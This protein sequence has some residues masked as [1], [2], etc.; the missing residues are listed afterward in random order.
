MGLKPPVKGTQL[1]G[2]IQVALIWSY[3]YE[4]CL[5]GVSGPKL[6]LAFS[7]GGFAA[8]LNIDITRRRVKDICMGLIMV[9]LV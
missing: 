1:E 7:M 5:H 9:S 8:D 3:L 4:A 6:S 2:T